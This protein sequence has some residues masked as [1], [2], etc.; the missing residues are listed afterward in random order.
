MTKSKCIE[1][2]TTSNIPLDKT[3]GIIQWLN[4][5]L[6]P[7]KLQH[8]LCKMPN[9][10]F[11]FSLFAF[12]LFSSIHYFWI[13]SI[14]FITFYIMEWSTYSL[15]C[16]QLKKI[17]ISKS[18]FFFWIHGI[19]EWMLVDSGFYSYVVKSNLR[20]EFCKWSWL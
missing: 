15:E 9:E 7:W 17:I 6:S 3:I 8:P 12:K 4:S 19:Q 18:I 10:P 1:C 11:F 2:W 14:T 13:C 16:F 20:S 5:W